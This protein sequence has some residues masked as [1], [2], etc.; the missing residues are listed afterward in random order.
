MLPLSALR[1]AGLENGVY[2]FT[3]ATADGSIRARMFAPLHG[4]AEDPAT[5][6]AAA[7]LAALL[8]DT[9]ARATLDGSWR[10]VQGVEMGRRSVID[11]TAEK[12]DGGI[13]PVTVAGGAVS[14]SEGWIEA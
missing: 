2:L 14:V 3:R 11:V 1:A 10:I 13:G 7:G 9:D 12:R 6:S 5:G 8:A 4:I